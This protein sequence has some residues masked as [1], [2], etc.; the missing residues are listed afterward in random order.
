MYYFLVSLVFGLLAYLCVADFSNKSDFED[1]TPGGIIAAILVFLL[2]WGLM[3]WLQPPLSLGYADWLAFFI[4]IAII[5]AGTGSAN[6]DAFDLRFQLKSL[7]PLAILLLGLFYWFIS[8]NSLFTSDT[9]QRML[10]VK[11]VADEVY[12]RDMAQI[13]PESMIL[14]DESLA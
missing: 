10:N 2:S 6:V 3:Y 11:E 14:V 12:T 9:K 7:I 1:S 8:S 13:Q 4:V 5:T